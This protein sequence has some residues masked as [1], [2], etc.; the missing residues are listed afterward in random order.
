MS[1]IG[2]S[3]CC[4]TPYLTGGEPFKL[5]YTCIVNSL[6]YIK[7]ILHCLQIMMS[8]MVTI[9]GSVAHPYQGLGNGNKQATQ[10]VVF[11]QPSPEMTPPKD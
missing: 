3:F 1:L 9:K 4:I 8:Y 10:R 6:S 2:I 5:Q 11:R 7:H